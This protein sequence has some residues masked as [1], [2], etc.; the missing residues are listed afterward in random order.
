[1]DKKVDAVNAGKLWNDVL[2]KKG[3]HLEVSRRWW[4][5]ESIAL[6]I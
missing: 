1:M 4:R 3:G 6:D 2:Y 5:S